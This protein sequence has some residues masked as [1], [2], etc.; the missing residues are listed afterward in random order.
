V[1]KDFQKITK[2]DYGVKVK[3]I[4]ARNPQANA[5]VEK[6]YQV[7]GNIIR[8]F[9]EFENNYLEEEDLWKGILSTAAIALGLFLVHVQNLVVI[10]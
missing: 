7:I 1:D 6:V 8:T 2:E 10:A 9:V 3:P 5:S 4:T